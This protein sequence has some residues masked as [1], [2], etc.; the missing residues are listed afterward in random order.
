MLLLAS[1]ITL[2]LLALDML[3]KYSIIIKRLFGATSLACLDK[4]WIFPQIPGRLKI[5]TTLTNSIKGIYFA[6]TSFHGRI[7]SQDWPAPDRRNSSKFLIF[8]FRNPL[9][10]QLWLFL[11]FWFWYKHRKH[12]NSP[13]VVL[14][15]KKKCNK[16]RK[17]YP[18]PPCLRKF[19][20]PPCIERMASLKLF[21]H[22]WL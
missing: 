11:N 3:C 1:E 12:W 7:T 19:V 20:T 10:L 21:N 8:F 13:L 14:S 18:P 9:W 2:D 4:F 16:I 6:V 17:W 15:L 5:F 22:K